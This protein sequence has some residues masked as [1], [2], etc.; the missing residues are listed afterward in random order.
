VKAP[1]LYFFDTGLVAYLTRHSSPEILMNG[2]I[3][4]AILENY[5]VTEIR[6]TSLNM[7]EVGRFN[8][9]EKF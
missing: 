2:A 7:G 9:R 8:I 6:K 1:K 4:A 5:I 3:N